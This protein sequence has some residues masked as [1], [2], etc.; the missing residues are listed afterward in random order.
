MTDAASRMGRRYLALW[1]PFLPT[2]RIRSAA[3]R[4]ATPDSA[5]PAEPFVLIEKIKGALRLAAVDQQALSQGLTPGLT[6]SDARARAPKMV[7]MDVDPAADAAFLESIADGCGRYTPLVAIDQPDG[8][9]LDVTGCAHLF[10][11][12][13]ALRTD[14]TRRLERIGLTVRMTL[15][16]TPDAARALARFGRTGAVAPGGEAEILCGLPI[17]A[18]IIPAESVLA[19]SRAGLKTIGDLAERPRA[20]LAAR[21]G[22][23][24]LAR[25]DR[26]LGRQDARITPHR[27]APD[28]IV[29][30]RFAEPIGRT[31]DFEGALDLLM[32]KAAGILEQRGEGGRVFEAS[33][34]RTDGIVRRVHVETGRPSRDRKSV[35]RL[36]REKLEALADPLDPGFGFDL[37]RLAVLVMQPLDPAQ[38]SLDGRQ[39]EDDEIAGLVERLVARFGRDR[40]QRF[41]ARDTHDPDREAALIPALDPSP[42][43]AIWRAP[44]PDDPPARPLHLFEPPQPIETLAEVPDGPP[45]RFRWRRMMHEIAR[46]EGPERIATEWWRRDAAT[47]DYYR[48]EDADGHRFWVFRD[49]LYGRETER[50]RWFL[51]GLFA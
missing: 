25:L 47:R 31:E 30:R 41:A 27:P 18:L 24:L 22:D 14:L 20:P 40:V 33:F 3:R 8:L 35:M 29:E 19:L 36:F 28:C 45:L 12:E 13:A 17:R 51:H 9:V 39:V 38:A 5:A 48:V 10:G 50:P 15:A 32:T 42:N 2:D 49:G 44:E 11:G 21:F 26:T 7:V 16:G 34:F 6:L 46:A 23:D 37:I 4:G 1:F 43:A